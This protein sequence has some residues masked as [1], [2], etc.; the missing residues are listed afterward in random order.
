MKL[1]AYDKQ[2]QQW[3]MSNDGVSEQKF[4]GFLSEITGW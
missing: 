1:T 2:E 4:C 3:R